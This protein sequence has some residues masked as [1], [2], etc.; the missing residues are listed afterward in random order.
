[1]PASAHQPFSSRSLDL[2]ALRTYSRNVRA[3]ATLKFGY[4]GVFFL[5]LMSFC[6]VDFFFHLTG[7]VAILVSGQ[8]CYHFS[9]SCKEMDI[10]LR[11]VWL[12]QRR[13]FW[14]NP[15]LYRT[16]RVLTRKDVT[17]IVSNQID[18]ISRAVTV[19]GMKLGLPV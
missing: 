9:L 17:H 5:R 10:Y 6:I 14:P 15:I 11:K 13:H 2:S 1:M 19:E 4:E 16:R 8:F 3:S 7:R 12:P 18:S